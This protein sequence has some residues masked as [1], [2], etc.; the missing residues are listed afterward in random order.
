MK[1]AT[2]ALALTLALSATQALAVQE[3]KG[4]RF[5]DSYALAGQTLQLNG[6]GVRVKFFIDVYA[7]ALY[8]PKKEQ[9]AAAVLGAPGVKSV[10]IVMLRDVSGDD[11]AEATEKGFNANHS[12]EELARHR[13]KLQELLTLM[14]SLG[15]VKKGSVVNIDLQPG[16]VNITVNGTPKGL[17]AAK[18]DFAVAVMKNWLGSKP[19][20]GDLKKALLGT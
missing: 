10:Q 19:V 18:E 8:L 16:G 9:S 5:A 15:T 3:V 14:K 13:P 6:A 1:R 2:F 12:E 4:V 17:I 20:D 7:A 11:F